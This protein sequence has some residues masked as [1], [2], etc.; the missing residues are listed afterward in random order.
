VRFSVPPHLENVIVR[1]TFL[2]IKQSKCIAKKK[3][4]T[5]ERVLG[6]IRRKTSKMVLYDTKIKDFSLNDKKAQVLIDIEPRNNDKEMLI[7][8]NWKL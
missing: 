7:L 4:K 3:L 2:I 6:H 8:I 1:A 5:K